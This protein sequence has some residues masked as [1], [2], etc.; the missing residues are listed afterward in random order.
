M[1]R[2]QE[3]WVVPHLWSQRTKV[4]RPMGGKSGE[5][6]SHLWGGPRS[7]TARGLGA[8]VVVIKDINWLENL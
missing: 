5:A 1:N 3:H 2:V 4:L 8:M 6:A 7:P